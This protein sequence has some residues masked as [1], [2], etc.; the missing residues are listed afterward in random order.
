M[1]PAAARITHVRAEC[2][3][4]VG[5]RLDEAVGAT[6]AEGHGGEEAR[7]LLEAVVLERHRRHRHRDVVGEEGHERVDVAGLVGAGEAVDER[8]LLGR[9]GT[10]RPH[11]GGRRGEPFLD[12][13]ARPLERARHGLLARVED[14]RDLAGAVAE[15]VAQD[16]HGARARR[17]RLERGEER[18]RDRFAAS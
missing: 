14:R 16:E 8:T 4:A 13:D 3:L 5:P 15:H 6:V 1:E 18:E 11:V 12:D 10:R 17:E 7:R 2:R 9:D